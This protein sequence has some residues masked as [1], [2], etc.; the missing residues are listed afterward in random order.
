MKK[1]GV[2]TPAQTDDKV[3]EIGDRVVAYAPREDVSYCHC[4]EAIG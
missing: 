3:M 4:E 2:F 1:A